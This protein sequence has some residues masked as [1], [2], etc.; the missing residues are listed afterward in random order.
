VFAFGPSLFIF[1][2]GADSMVASAAEGFFVIS[3]M[4]VGYVY[5]P[6][7]LT[8]TKQVFKKLLKRAVLLWALTILFTLIFTA[9]AAKTGANNLYIEGGSAFQWAYNT[10]LLRH[11][12]GL[13]DFLSRY[14]WFMV[15]APFA[16]WL[17]AKRHAWIVI[18]ASVTLWY[19]LRTNDSFLPF[20]AWQIIFMHSIIVGYYFPSLQQKFRSLSKR[21][22]TIIYRS[23]TG[24]GLSSLIA[25]LVIFVVIP[26][27]EPFCHISIA[28]S[29]LESINVIAKETLLP[30]ADKATLDPLRL[31]IGAFWFCALFMFIRK[32]EA[33]IDKKTGG[34]LQ[35]FGKNSLFFYTFHAVLVFSIGYLRP[36]EGSNGVVL[37]TIVAIIALAI[38]YVA[39]RYKPVFMRQLGRTWAV[40]NRR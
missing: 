21:S 33:S 31:I 22:Q 15:A 4:M 5:G 9:W 1:I 37:N 6:K 24:I 14:A 10:L 40:I 13:A 16:L 7:I 17:I 3:G 26:H 39:V 23:V 29:Y 19:F 35:L 30:L 11:T 12:Y 27:I 20:S 28:G 34:I 36:P 2:A 18:V 32:H 38:L 8:Q 25:S